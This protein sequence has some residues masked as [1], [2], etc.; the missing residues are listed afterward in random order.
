MTLKALASAAILSALATTAAQAT[1]FDF[2]FSA[3]PSN[4][5]TI[6]DTTDPTF[7][8][9]GTIE[10]NVGAGET[11]TSMDL[12][13][14]DV[15]A[16]RDGFDNVLIDNFTFFTGSVSAD[17]S[18]ASLTDIFDETSGIG[19]LAATADCAPFGI[20]GFNVFFG[21]PTA[22]AQFDSPASALAA[23]QLT[24]PAPVSPV[25][26]PA[27]GLLLLSALGGVSALKRRKARAE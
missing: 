24:G 3:D 4:N 17:G 1:T 25:P 8:L 12:I 10:L 26:L 22:G 19:C 6:Q 13:L 18:F 15:V 27:G 7:Q 11:F 2:F 20:S 5:A 9:T 16:S 14:V 23:F 21:S